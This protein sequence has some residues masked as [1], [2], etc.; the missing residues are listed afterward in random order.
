MNTYTSLTETI[1]YVFRKEVGVS[2]PEEDRNPVNLDLSIIAAYFMLNDFLTQEEVDRYFIA[3]LNG[4]SV[5][6]D[7]YQSIYDCIV[8][9][10]LTPEIS[11][12]PDVERDF[13]SLYHYV[14]IN[15]FMSEEE[16]ESLEALIDEN[17]ANQ[18]QPPKVEEVDDFVFVDEEEN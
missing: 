10:L 7:E 3:K 13:V 11:K 12:I 18:K 9:C 6:Q 16:M 1:M 5:A 15:D 2:L 8:H 4:K 17:I 14:Q